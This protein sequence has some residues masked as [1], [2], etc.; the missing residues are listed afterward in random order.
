MSTI[1]VVIP[2]LNDAEFLRSCLA[3]LELQSRPADEIIVVDNGSTDATADVA[4]A[5]GARLLHEP[6][7]GIFPATATGFDAAA[8][9]IIAR[10]DADSVPPCDWLERIETALDPLMTP[11]AVTGPAE[12]Y[13]AN[14]VACWVGRHVYLGIYFRGIAA[15]LGHSPVFG[16]NFAMHRELWLLTR[17]RAHRDLRRVHDD[18]DFSVNLPPG[19]TVVF[20]RDLVVAVSARPLLSWE[21]LGKRISLAYYTLAINARERSFRARRAD[22]RAA[23][24]QGHDVVDSAAG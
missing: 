16:S 17:D 13:G 4:R 10:L 20:D 18:F 1:S 11:A 8:G 23:V 3:A 9:D 15:L 2:A 5:A 21:A 14:R 12:F 19:S 24:W 6:Q 7:R 22:H